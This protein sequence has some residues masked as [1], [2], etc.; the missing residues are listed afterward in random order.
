[1]LLDPVNQSPCLSI[2]AF[3]K[4]NSFK[5]DILFNNNVLEILLLKYN[6]NIH[7]QDLFNFIL[8]VKDQKIKVIGLMTITPLDNLVPSSSSDLMQPDDKISVI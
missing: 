4:K 2:H 1:M 7:L 6:Y 3:Y 8:L 5:L